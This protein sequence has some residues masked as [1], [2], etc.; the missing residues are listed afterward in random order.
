MM[1]YHIGLFMCLFVLHHSLAFLN[2]DDSDPVETFQLRVTP[3][4]VNRHTTDKM[5]LRCERN[6]KVT[7]EMHQIITM[8]IVKQSMTGWT[9]VA[10]QRIAETSPRV[11]GSVTASS[12]LMGDISNVFLQ[13]NWDTIG[14]DNFGKFM[15]E[16]AGVD[17]Q[18]NFVKENSSEIDIQESKI[19]VDYFVL[20]LKKTNI[21]A[22]ELNETVQTE[23][24]VLRKDLKI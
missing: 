17:A 14:R 15:C 18:Y 4:Q 12:Q 10:E 11:E 2:N 13:V 5:T 6:P 19:P 7:T 23:I 9:V 21:M 24:Q 20:L 8:K 16:V 22:E 3:A 1:F